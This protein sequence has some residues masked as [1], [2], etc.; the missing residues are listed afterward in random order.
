MHTFTFVVKPNESTSFC[1]VMGSALSQRKVTQHANKPLVIRL[2]G[3]LLT[4][5]VKAIYIHI[6]TSV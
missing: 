2:C 5:A 3:S 1:H 4:V 6:Y